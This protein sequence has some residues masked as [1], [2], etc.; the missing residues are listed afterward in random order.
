VV[1]KA[2]K[3]ICVQAV[4]WGKRRTDVPILCQLA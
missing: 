2:L 3:P 1:E 4:G